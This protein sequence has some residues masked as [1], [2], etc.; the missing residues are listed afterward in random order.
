MECDSA[1]THSLSSL[2]NT[3]FFGDVRSLF[4]RDRNQQDCT[5]SQVCTYKFNL[6]AL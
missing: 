1:S 6:E 4:Y 5:T 2:N 3:S